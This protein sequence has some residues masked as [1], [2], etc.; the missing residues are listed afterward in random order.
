[1]IKGIMSSSPY[2]NVGSTNHPYINMSTPSAGMMRYNGN[3]ATIEIYDGS[4]WQ[5]CNSFQE[6]NLS[7]QANEILEW[8]RKKM[9]E[10][11]LRTLLASTHPAVAVALENLK[12]AEE[13]L[14]TTIHLS[15]HHET[16]T[17]S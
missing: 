3:S 4:Y 6:I 12:R 7:N 14:Q 15:K 10:E 16:Q 5:L 9:Q 11:Q 13:Q 2:L 1:M 17:T 8:G